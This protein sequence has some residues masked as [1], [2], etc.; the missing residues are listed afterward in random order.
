MTGIGVDQRISKA[1]G[2]TPRATM[3]ARVDLAP[4]ASAGTVSA[5]DEDVEG[6]GFGTPGVS[7]VGV[8]KSFDVTRAL[9]GCSFSASLGEIHAIFGGNGCGKS[10][11]AKVI[12]GVLPIDSGQVNVLGH[13]PGSPHEARAVGVATVF[14]EVLVADESSILDNLYI[15]ADRLWSRTAS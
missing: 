15:G 8:R 3:T 5:T 11:L 9:D 13:T 7:V 2:E 6:A 4:M 14:Q 10:T 12:S 1:T